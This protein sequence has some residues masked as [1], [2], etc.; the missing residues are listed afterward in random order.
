MLVPTDAKQPDPKILTLDEMT[1][2]VVIDNGHAK[3]NVMQIFGNHTGR[4]HRGELCLR[5]ARPCPDL[6]L[7]RLGRHHSHPRRHPGTQARR[8]TVQRHSR[9]GHRPGPSCKWASVTP[10]KRGGPLCSAPASLPFPPTAPSAWKSNIRS[11][12]KWNRETHIFPFP[13]VPMSTI[14]RLQES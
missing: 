5:V 1:I 6:R 13:C 10:T 12:F 4:P 9:P 2:R 14:R 3:V 11:V 7:R 8:R